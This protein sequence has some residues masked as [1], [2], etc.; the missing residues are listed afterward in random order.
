MIEDSRETQADERVRAPRRPARRP[1]VEAPAPQFIADEVKHLI[2]VGEVPLGAPVTEKW[3]TGRFQASRTTVREALNLLVAARYLDQEPYKS[4]RVRSYSPE[5]VAD[6][7]EA[8]RLLEGFA[9]DNCARASEEA[10]AQLRSAFATYA[11]ESSARHQDATAMAH[12]ELHV[13]IVGLT[14]N[15]EL[16][17]AERDLMIGSLLL[18]DLINWHLRDSEKMYMEHLRLVNAL[19]GPDPDEARRLTDGHLD[20]VHTAARIQLA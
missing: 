12:V 17:L 11:T 10:R 14:G 6:I 8:R 18:I 3:L 16:V 7:L 15:R 2:L 19:L 4:A 13:A 9:A 1:T 5:E 20:M